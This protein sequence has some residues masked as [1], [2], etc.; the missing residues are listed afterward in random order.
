MNDTCISN[1]E[2]SRLKEIERKWNERKKILTNV[3]LREEGIVPALEHEME[4]LRSMEHDNDNTSL[5]LRCNRVR[6]SILRIVDD[7]KNMR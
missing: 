5:Q 7:I 3:I 1:E 6:Y 4:N 2:Y